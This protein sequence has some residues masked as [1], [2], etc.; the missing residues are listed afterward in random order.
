MACC[1]AK[2]L[3]V[4]VVATDFN[5]AFVSRLDGRV[6]AYDAVESNRTED[7]KPMIARITIAAAMLFGLA[8]T[9]YAVCLLCP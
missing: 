3:L 5:V 2:I 1:L 7:E 4:P 8:T 6:T 9:V